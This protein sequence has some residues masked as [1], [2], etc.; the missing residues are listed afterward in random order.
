LKTELRDDRTPAAFLSPAGHTPVGL[1][2]T[3]LKNRSFL[4]LWLAQLLSQIVFNAANYGVIAIVTAV[5]HSTVMVGVAIISFTLPAVPFS[6]LAGVYVDY[7]NK[8][9][10]LWVSNALR[11][12]AT[13]L[14][15]VALLW[16]PH[17]LIPLYFLTLVISLVTQFFTPAEASA[18]PLLVSKHDLAPALSLFN[19][20]LTIAQALGF[21]I[22]GGLLTAL[23]PP[24]RLSLGSLRVQVQSFAVLFALVALVYI[25]CSGL[26]L[27]IPA[28]AL[29]RGPSAGS[30]LPRSLGKQVW[31][32]I[33]R[34]A[35]ETWAYTRKDRQL[36]LALLQVSFVSI[37]LLVI[38]ELAGPF[39]VTVLHLP[40]EDLPLIFAPAGL[41]LV[42]GSLLLPS[43]TRR[44][45][46]S[47]TIALGSLCT[48]A[49]LIVIPLG[50]SVLSQFALLAL[51]ILLFVGAITF[52]IGVALEMVNIPAQTVMQE[53]AP[54]E[55]RARVSSF[56]SM[57]YNA[58]SIPVLLFAG[59]IADTL[60][61][62][63]V[64]Y[65]L[66]AAILGFSS[67]IQLVGG[68]L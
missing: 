49:G 29:Q 59:V 12:V 3:V 11:A 5:T 63:T 52:V 30:G 21:L 13:G 6:L 42:L 24:F 31:K 17:M 4:L 66:A 41:G 32:V 23:F 51:S 22:V 54:A 19:I 36:L 15:V 46:K 35:G 43:L 7:L 28:R 39:V 9:L 1:F 2:R 14:L 64:M 38:G 18:I 10:V 50:R 58:G 25:I 62:E 8:R 20:T 27:A 48:A 37:L 16:N 60:G 40:V 26:L 61:T 45:G 56:Q 44:L 68:T 57:L 47:R 65:G 55:E 33:R 34:D 67:G 53:Q